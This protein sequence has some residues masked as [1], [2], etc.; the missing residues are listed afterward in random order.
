MENK[1]YFLLSYT[2][3]YSM[4]LL[5]DIQIQK[6]FDRIGGNLLERVIC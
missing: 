6:L 5:I 1:F 2:V 4:I 3:T